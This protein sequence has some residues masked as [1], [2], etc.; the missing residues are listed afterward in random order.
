V[1]RNHGRPGAAAAPHEIR[2]WLYRL[3]PFDAEHD[4][5]LVSPPPLDA[6]TVRIDGSLEESQQ[7]LGEVVAG[8][9]RSGAI[10]VVLGGGHETAFGHFL[11]YAALA[12]PCGIINIDAHLD[13]RPCTDGL[14]HSGSPFRQALEHPAQPLPGTHYV[15]LG[16]E[17]AGVSRQHRDYLRQRGGVIRW[18]SEV[19]KALGK[20]FSQECARLTADGASVYLSVDADA[21]R[22]S[23]VPGVSAPNANGLKGSE[24]IAVARLAGQSAQVASFDLVEINPT[25]DR[26]GQSSRWAALVVW[27]F[28][29][30]LTRRG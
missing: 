16:A 11:G 19:R 1:R 30:G 28:L 15:C 10:P 3:T 17:P 8:I 7:A 13:V 2:H 29:A 9:L 21:V 18:N 27:H 6:G 22:A 14:G 12:R 4:I 23:D 25:L 26:D 5:E 24:I 20:H